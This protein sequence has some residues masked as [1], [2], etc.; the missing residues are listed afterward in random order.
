MSAAQFG[1][2][3]GVSSI[4]AFTDAADALTQAAKSI[5]LSHPDSPDLAF[6]YGSIITDG[7]DGRDAPSRN[8]CVFADREVDRSP[9]GSGVTAGLP[10]CLQRGASGLAKRALLK[11]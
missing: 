7:G 8:V 11:A 5:A 2:E 9:T 3:F 1:L 6:L 4:R 10:R